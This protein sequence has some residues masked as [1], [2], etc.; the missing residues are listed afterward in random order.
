MYL[1]GAEKSQSYV[2]SYD[3]MLQFVEL[4]AAINIC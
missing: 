1:E 2:N 3:C 4:Q